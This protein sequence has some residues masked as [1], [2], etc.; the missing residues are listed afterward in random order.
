M[1]DFIKIQNLIAD[2][3]Y[4]YSHPLIKIFAEFN[5]ATGEINSRREN[6]FSKKYQIWGEYYGLTF[7]FYE[8]G[9]T[10]IKGSLHV[11]FN[12]GQHNY[13]DFS[14]RDLET[15]LI[16]L[17]HT[18]QID[19][20]NSRLNNFEF[21]VNIELPYNP[22]VLIDSVIMYR[23]KRFDLQ[24][25]ENKHFRECNDH[26]QFKIKIYNKGLQHNLNKDLLRFELH[27]SVMEKFNDL[28]VF[29]LADLIKPGKREILSKKLIETFSGL[30]IGDI[31]T[32]DY[33]LIQAIDEGYKSPEMQQNEII[34]QVKKS[35]FYREYKGLRTKDK[36]RY[37][38]GYSFNFWDNIHPKN[39]QEPDYTAKRSKSNR[40]LERFKELLQITGANQIHKEANEQIIQK[41]K[42][43]CNPQKSVQSEHI[44]NTK[45]A[46]KIALAETPK[47]VQSENYYYNLS[48]YHS[49]GI[50]KERC[51]ITEIDISKQKK[52]SKFLSER[53]IKELYLSDEV[54]FKELVLKYGSKRKKLSIE[55]QFYFIAHNI[56]NKHNRNQKI[57]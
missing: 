16:D 53:T 20:E 57:K 5:P 41:T 15:V 40:E 28:A 55:K 44:T 36:L 12:R 29:T 24:T 39:S 33:S 47:T 50:K 42:E 3:E 6:R 49:N 46:W 11:Y 4:L 25:G 2:Q 19:I 48:L 27:Y 8:D 51:L 22:N 56:R 45:T 23:R 7:L 38:L 1:I 43:L 31:R 34:N 9:T 26:E 35:R 54:T 13:N 18:F 14:F 17:K 52:G 32:M 37:C 10:E 21:G 30:L